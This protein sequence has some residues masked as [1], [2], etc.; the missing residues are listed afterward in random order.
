MKKL[1]LVLL[2]TVIHAAVLMPTISA[3]QIE[4]D[5]KELEVKNTMLREFL[6]GKV[7]EFVLPPNSSWSLM[8]YYE[9]LRSLEEYEKERQANRKAADKFERSLENENKPG[10]EVAPPAYSMPKEIF[11]ELLRASR[12]AADLLEREQKMLRVT[13]PEQALE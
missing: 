12:E 1:F 7:K 5:E 4:E 8:V 2:A 10:H 6:K 11:Q 9:E 13:P 3:W